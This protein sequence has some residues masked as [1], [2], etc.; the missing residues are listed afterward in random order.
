MSDPVELDA[1]LSGDSPVNPTVKWNRRR[2]LEWIQEREPEVLEDD[3]LS[4]FK[5]AKIGGRAFLHANY[6][7]FHSLLVRV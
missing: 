2:V 3:D 7:F 5:K 6:E 1:T 4:N